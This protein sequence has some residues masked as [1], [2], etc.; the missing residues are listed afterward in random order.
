ML[1]DETNTGLVSTVGGGQSI[2]AA[3]YA[4]PPPSHHAESKI[5]KKRS[6]AEAGASSQPIRDGIVPSDDAMLHAGTVRGADI[7]TQADAV[8]LEPVN[9]GLPD[10]R[11]VRTA[12][13]Q[14]AR[15]CTHARTSLTPLALAGTPTKTA[16]VTLTD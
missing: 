10:A 6:A 14:W 2:V 5:V 4:P 15:M 9:D 3:Q 12:T 1:S 8:K 7:Y 11:I 13:I 16:T